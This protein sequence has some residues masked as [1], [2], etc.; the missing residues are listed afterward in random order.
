MLRYLAKRLS[1]YAVLLI[2]AVFLAYAI[3][4]TALQPRTYFDAKVPARPP[5]RSSASSPR[6]T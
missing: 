4:A 2:A 3:S 6:S 1:Y 5:S